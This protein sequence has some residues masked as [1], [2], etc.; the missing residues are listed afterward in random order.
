MVLMTADPRMVSQAIPIPH[1]S[2][3]GA[4][5][6][7]HFGA[8][9]IYPPTIQPVMDKRIPIWIKNT[10][11]PDDYGALIHSQDG[12]GRNYPVTGISGIQKIAPAHT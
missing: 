10:F 8:K 11:A 4:M 2:Y 6:L 5:E 3:E 1:I 7:S 9:V 12:D